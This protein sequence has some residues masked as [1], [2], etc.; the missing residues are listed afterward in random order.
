MTLQN[1][2]DSPN[3]SS[4]PA[5]WPGHQDLQWQHEENGGVV[6]WGRAEDRVDV[7]GG[8]DLSLPLFLHMYMYM[9]MSMYMYIRIYIYMYMM[10][11]VDVFHLHL[12]KICMC[13][14]PMGKVWNWWIDE[15]L[16]RMVEEW[17]IA[18]PNPRQG[19]ASNSTSREQNY[20]IKI[21]YGN[22][23]W[24]WLVCMV[25]TLYRKSRQLIQMMLKTIERWV[26][27]T[28]LST[29][30]VSFVS[31]ARGQPSGDRISG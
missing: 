3:A 10:W 22:T 29:G 12:G 16:G 11:N 5:P 26:F 25:P 9:Y 19:M 7:E 6:H 30:S 20:E 28:F 27:R 2:S 8:M 24:K 1:L 4:L 23:I 21:M 14:G 17:R 13:R 31:F 15:S 18:H